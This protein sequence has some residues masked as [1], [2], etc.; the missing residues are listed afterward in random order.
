VARELL[1][2]PQP[3]PLERVLTL[4]ANEILKSTIGDFAL[5]LD[6]YHVIETDA[7]HEGMGFLLDHLPPQMHVILATRADPP[8]PLSRLR[9]RG[10]LTEVR[11]ADLRFD[12]SESAAFLHMVMGIDLS[13]SDLAA[14]ERRTEGWIAGLQLAALSLQGRTDVT[15]FLAAFT[16]SHRFV[17]DYLSEEVF[18]RQPAVVQDFLLQTSILERLSGPLCEAVTGQEA[19]QARLETLEHANLFVVAL[20]DERRWYRYHHLLT[21]VLRSRLHQ[22]QPDLVPELHRR[23]SAWYLEQGLVHEGI[24]H[25][26]SAGDVERV[27]E[28]IEGQGFSLGR[29]PADRSQTLLG[30]LNA[31]PNRLVESRPILCILHAMA[32]TLTNHPQEAEA[33]LQHAEQGLH[34][35][36]PASEIKRMQG[37]VATVRANLAGFAGDALQAA[38]LAKQALGLLPETE[39]SM[40]SAAR[41]LLAHG[42][43]NDGDVTAAT[44]QLVTEV[45]APLR[46]RGNRAVALSALTALARL[47]FLQG[48]LRQA[49]MTYREAAQVLPEREALEALPN[50]AAYYFGLGDILREWNHLEAV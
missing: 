33:R 26:L 10:Q 28:V 39:R 24:D 20:D 32:F 5:V 35:G 25:G 18:S 13:A 40:R 41:M 49:A 43:Y 9:V 4:L 14:L 29:G 42:Y 44:E 45:V 11:A 19:S 50:S 3:V 6:D 34:P 8:L 2:A 1:E 37:S 22:E 48:K 47:Q 30:W 27:A 7:I 38:T 15:G 16:G 17:L 31:L 12:T 46:T 21:D 36:M 23:A